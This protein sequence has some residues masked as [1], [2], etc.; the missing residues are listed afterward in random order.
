[1]IEI[2]SNNTRKRLREENVGQDE[3]AAAA[4]AANK[5][6]W[7][8]EEVTA[9]GTAEHNSGETADAINKAK[10]RALSRLRT[11]SSEQEGDDAGHSSEC[12]DESENWNKTEKASTT[13][14]IRRN[15]SSPVDGDFQG[16][17]G[18]RDDEQDNGYAWPSPGTL[19]ALRNGV[20]NAD[21]DTVI[22]M[23]SFVVADPWEGLVAQ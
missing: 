6:N 8:A 11:L 3:G 4:A 5:P 23:P 21:G 14:A 16:E 17:D 2:Q 7:D 10:S 15:D 9:A 13:A 19:H 18:G 12:E 22:F 1:M 20:V